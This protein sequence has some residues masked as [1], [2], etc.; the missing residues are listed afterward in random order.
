MTEQ[1][2]P[3]IRTRSPASFSRAGSA[4]D[5]AH[6]HLVRGTHVKRL[7]ATHTFRSARR[8]D[9]SSENYGRLV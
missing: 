3:H 6:V 5:C 1:E 2:R 9:A 4:H 7:R 8:T